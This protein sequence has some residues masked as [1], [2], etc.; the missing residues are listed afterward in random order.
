MQH[1]C[2]FSNACL[3]REKKSESLW[4]KKKR[5]YNS[6]KWIVHTYISTVETVAVIGYYAIQTRDDNPVIWIWRMVIQRCKCIVSTS[7]LV[8]QDPRPTFLRS[9]RLRRNFIGVSVCGGETKSDTA[10]FPSDAACRL[11]PLA[12]DREHNFHVKQELSF[13]NMS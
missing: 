10:T 7:L 3:I 4:K 8:G 13:R 2:F 11:L 1:V 12:S 9:R 5:N 6:V